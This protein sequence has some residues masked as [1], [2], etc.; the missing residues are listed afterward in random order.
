MQDVRHE[1]DA[2]D[3]QRRLWLGGAVVAIRRDLLGGAVEP[4]WINLWSIL[5]PETLL[6]DQRA[7]AFSVD[8]ING[9]CGVD[10]GSARR[11]E[12]RPRV[13]RIARSAP[14][15]RASFWKRETTSRPTARPLGPYR[16]T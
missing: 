16:F 8:Q 3:R 14:F 12:N 2:R 11:L 7:E 6:A 4:V 1:V 13:T 5:D 15:L 9:R 10:R